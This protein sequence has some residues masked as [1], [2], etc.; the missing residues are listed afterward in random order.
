MPEEMRVREAKRGEWIIVSTLIDAKEVS[1]E[2]LHALY[3]KRWHVEL[4][5]RAVKNVMGM[6]VLR[7]QKSGEGDQGSQCLSAGLKHLFAYLREAIATLRLPND[8]IG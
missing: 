1:K 7:W 6:D 5:L 4:D 8:L 2:E 3:V